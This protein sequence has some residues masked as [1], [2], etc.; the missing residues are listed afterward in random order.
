MELR[1]SVTRR[2]MAVILRAGC[3]NPQVCRYYNSA[4]R[5]K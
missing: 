3:R 5:K 2:V 1:T 4:P